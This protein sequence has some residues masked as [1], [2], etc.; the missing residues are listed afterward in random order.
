MV[1][2]VV[3]KRSC[4]ICILFTLAI[5]LVAEHGP[6]WKLSLKAGWRYLH[7]VN[8]LLI[9]CWRDI[10]NIII[11]I[12]S[13]TRILAKFASSYTYSFG[14]DR[15]LYL[16]VV[17]WRRNT[18][19]RWN[20]AIVQYH[21]CLFLFMHMTIWTIEEHKSLYGQLYSVLWCE[22]FVRL[23]QDWLGMSTL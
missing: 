18:Y 4:S 23:E 1:L 7:L 16:W 17:P 2:V 3:H 11:F 22:Q 5:V 21:S 13:I 8:L 12:F 10:S 20:Q 15:S 9:V 14:R 6:F 19:V